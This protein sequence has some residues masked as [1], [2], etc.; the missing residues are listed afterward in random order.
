MTLV[1][2][3]KSDIV[4][5]QFPASEVYDAG[6]LF[7]VILHRVPIALGCIDRAIVVDLTR[8][9]VRSAVRCSTGILMDCKHIGNAAESN[10]C[11][12]LILVF[13]SGRR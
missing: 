6:V 12:V 3:R 8:E 5:A 4:T 2:V 11:R 10:I 1:V 9:D 13:Q 7:L